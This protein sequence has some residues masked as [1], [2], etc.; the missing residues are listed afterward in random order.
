M[1]VENSDYGRDRGRSGIDVIPGR[2]PIAS[3]HFE[4]NQVVNSNDMLKSKE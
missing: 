1:G 3:R 2:L 4:Q